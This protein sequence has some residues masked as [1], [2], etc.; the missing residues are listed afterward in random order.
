MMFFVTAVYAQSGRVE[1][2]SGWALNRYKDLKRFIQKSGGLDLYS[3]VTLKYINGK[4]PELVIDNQDRVD[5]TKYKSQDDLHNLFQSKGFKK[6]KTSPNPD[7]D[8]NCSEWAQN[9]EC[10]KNPT[11]MKINC[12]YSCL[13]IEL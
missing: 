9:G 6:E 1:T 12:K 10:E 2:C 5:L 8:S 4:H 7:N 11:F 13:K 3:D